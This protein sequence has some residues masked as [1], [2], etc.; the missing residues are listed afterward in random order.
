MIS[1]CRA[2]FSTTGL[3]WN[4]LGSNLGSRCK[5]QVNV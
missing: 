1:C 5:L 3:T 4:A 2:I